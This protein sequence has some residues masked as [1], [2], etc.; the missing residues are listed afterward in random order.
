MAPDIGSATPALTTMVTRQPDGTR[1]RHQ[2]AR[3]PLREVYEHIDPPAPATIT[4][5]HDETG[6]LKPGTLDR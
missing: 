2:V 6:T 4:S 3:I 1:I 5:M